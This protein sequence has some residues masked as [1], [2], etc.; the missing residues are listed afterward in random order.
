MRYLLDELM[1]YE[2]GF[3]DILMDDRPFHRHE[4]FMGD[5]EHRHNTPPVQHTSSHVLSRGDLQAFEVQLIQNI[6]ALLTPQHL[7][8]D[9]HGLQSSESALASLS[10]HDMYLTPISRGEYLI[11]YNMQYNL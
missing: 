2:E 1:V 6:T 10:Q 8:R 5:S 3:S 7:H 9:Y 11:Y 4:T